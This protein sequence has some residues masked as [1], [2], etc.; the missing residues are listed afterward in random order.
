MTAD[1]LLLADL[2][3]GRQLLPAEQQRLRH[4]P[5]RPRERRGRAEEEGGGEGEEE[6]ELTVFVRELVLDVLA[7]ELLHGV[8]ELLLLLQERNSPPGINSLHFLRTSWRPERREI[9]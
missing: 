2:P 9:R 6:E 3:A 8:E 7:E 1:L 4:L 5:E